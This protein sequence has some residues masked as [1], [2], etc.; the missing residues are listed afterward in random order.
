MP[1]LAYLWR[2]QIRAERIQAARP[3]RIKSLR[4][5]EGRG[6]KSEPLARRICKRVSGK[7][8]LVCAYVQVVS[9]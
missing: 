9:S 7:G 5:K 3:A 4:L 8:K 2:R 6:V 1:I